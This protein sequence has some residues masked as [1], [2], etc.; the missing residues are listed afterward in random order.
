MTG[1]PPR[2]AP[3]KYAAL[4]SSFAA[5]PGIPPTLD[6]FAMRSGNNYPNILARRLGAELT[7]LSVSGAT[8]K[9][10]LSEPQTYYFSVI[11]F[12]PQVTCLPPDADIVTITGG[13]NDLGYIG[14]II[15]DIWNTSF[16]GSLF[17]RI[18]PA[19]AGLSIQDVA[20]RFTALIDEIRKIAPKAHI[21]LVEYPTVFGSDTPPHDVPLDE[22]QIRHHRSVAEA[23]EKAYQL[24]VEARPAVTLVSVGELS[25]EHGVGSQHP[26]VSGAKGMVGFHP[27]LE[28]MQ[29]IADIIYE[30]L[31]ADKLI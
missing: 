11:R 21:V 25:R 4:G 7:D 16:M 28:G 17:S 26:W 29:A 31:K 3:L 20:D 15:R 14:G 27:N 18:L 23:L 24:A 8:L 19:P 6:R 30:K 13:G 10:I 2:M 5:G 1:H 12:E 22:A 9:N